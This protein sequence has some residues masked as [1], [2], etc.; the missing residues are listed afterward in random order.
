MPRHP[1][2]TEKGKGLNCIP[3]GKYFVNSKKNPTP[4]YSKEWV[5]RSF[6]PLSLSAKTKGLDDGTIA[7]DVAVV[8]IVEQGAAFTY[9]LGQ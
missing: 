3:L 4:T 7:L 8:Q 6:L 5:T 2:K 1:Q 9:Q